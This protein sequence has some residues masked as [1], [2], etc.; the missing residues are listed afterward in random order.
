MFVANVAVGKAFNT[1][2]SNLPQ[3]ACPP[4]GYQSVVGEVSNSQRMRELSFPVGTLHECMSWRV[5][6]WYFRPNV[7]AETQ[8]S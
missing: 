3:S 6:T 5:S 8:D 1:K 2:S 7:S 4:L